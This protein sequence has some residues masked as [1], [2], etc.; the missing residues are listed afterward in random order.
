MVPPTPPHLATLLAR[1][2]SMLRLPESPGESPAVTGDGD[3]LR[4]PRTGRVFRVEDGVLDL[5]G[6]GFEKTPAQKPL[7]IPFIAGAYDRL[8]PRLAWVL[9]LP[10]FEREVAGVMERLAIERGDVV[11]DVACGH[12]NFT[13]ELARRVGGDGLVIGVDIAGAMLRRAAAHVRAAGLGNVLLVRGDAMELPIADESFAKVN[14]SGGLHGI[15]DLRLALAEFARVS[16]VGGR[17]AASGFA[18]A[19]HD[20]LAGLKRRARER[21]DLHFVRMAWLRQEL[22]RAG[23]AKVETE[24][25]ST[26]MGYC[27]ARRGPTERTGR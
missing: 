21:F 24:M 25:P 11:L 7:D 4:C 1:A 16:Q 3:G 20:R 19:P 27:W 12:G 2:T 5:L 26:W 14:C 22:E 17:L 6:P 9:G 8:R 23:F 15:P 18:T 13:L 10:A